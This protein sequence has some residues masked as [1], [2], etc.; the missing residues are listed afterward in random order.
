MVRMPNR[1]AVPLQ[2]P[3]DLLGDP[4]Q[5][6]MALHRAM[7]ALAREGK[8]PV[9]SLEM[10]QRNGHSG[11]MEYGVPGH[12]VDA[13]RYGYIGPNLPAPLGQQ[14]KAKGNKWFLTQ[15]AG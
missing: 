12:L 10:R 13:L 11:D 7:T 6:P 5:A 14:W 2:Q 4:G 3:D 1:G 9:T 15:L 8:M